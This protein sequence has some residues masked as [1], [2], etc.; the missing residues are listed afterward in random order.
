M[1]TVQGS[2]ARLMRASVKRN[3]EEVIKDPTA[4]Y[5]KLVEQL[6]FFAG[7]MAADAAV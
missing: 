1:S 4:A 6:I 7:A 3:R 2:V 5:L